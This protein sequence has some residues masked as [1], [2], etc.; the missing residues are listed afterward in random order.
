MANFKLAARIRKLLE[1]PPS[2]SH[3]EVKCKQNKKQV[4]LSKFIVELLKEFYACTSV[5][6]I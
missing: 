4:S 5:E 2:R 6:I 1:S 3:A